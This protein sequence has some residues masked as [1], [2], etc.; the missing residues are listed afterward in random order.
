VDITTAEFWNVPNNQ[1]LPTLS[2]AQLLAQIEVDLAAGGLTGNPNLGIG[3]H[4]TG[5]AN[6]PGGGRFPIPFDTVIFDDANFLDIGGANPERMTIPDLDPPITRVVV[7]GSQIWNASTNGNQRAL[8]FV[9]NF[10]EITG[11]SQ[12]SRAIT[13]VPGPSNRILAVSPPL[14]C[15]AGDFFETQAIISGGAATA[16]NVNVAG[17]IIVIR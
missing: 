15:V 4:A 10:G 1:G 14:N 5:D 9:Q 13:P 17:W 7:G 11:G 2:Y 6:I 16:V 3:C 8:V 12:D